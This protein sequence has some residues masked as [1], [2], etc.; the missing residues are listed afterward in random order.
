M[1]EKFDIPALCLKVQSVLSLFSTGRTSGLVLDSGACVT[2]SV[3]IYEGYTM[4]YGT[5]KLVFGGNDITN[6]FGRMLTSKSIKINENRSIYDIVNIMKEKLC[7]TAL[8]YNHELKKPESSFEIDYELPDG[9][10][11]KVG[12]ERFTVM[13]S[14]FRPEIL[15]IENVSV[16]KLVNLSIN[17]CSSDLRND[18]YS[19]IH[20]NGGSTLFP[21]FSQRLRKEIEILDSTAKHIH[22]TVPNNGIY[23]TW[24]GGSLFSSLPSFIDIC[25]KKDEYNEYGPSFTQIKFF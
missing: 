5:L 21:G 2:F 23:S 17:K 4:P 12:N 20:L 19:N 15:G 11:V 1:F 6:C 8:N 7:Y 13:E 3:P 14:L 22:I 24:L 18:F 25:M 16:Q 10:N 9:S